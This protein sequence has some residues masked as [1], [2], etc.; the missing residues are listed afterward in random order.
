M[1]LRP[2][3][4]LTEIKTFVCIIPLQSR[5]H[6]PRFPFR[7]TRVTGALGTRLFPLRARVVRLTSVK[8]LLQENRSTISG[9]KCYF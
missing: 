9:I 2:E 6:S 4:K 5:Y 7:W 8:M 3:I 1:K